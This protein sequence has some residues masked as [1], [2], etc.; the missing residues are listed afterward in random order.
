MAIVLSGQVS[1][2]RL[3]PMVT[4]RALRGGTW[5]MG[6]LRVSGL[7]CALCLHTVGRVPLHQHSLFTARVLVLASLSACS[8]FIFARLSLPAAAV[9]VSSCQHA[10]KRVGQPP[11]VCRSSACLRWVPKSCCGLHRAP[12]DARGWLATPPYHQHH[13]GGLRSIA[14]LFR[15]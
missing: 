8:G 7:P 9:N 6:Y 2:G 11:T 13:G 15:A 5:A 3:L 10:A 4:R 12:F 1:N 14:A